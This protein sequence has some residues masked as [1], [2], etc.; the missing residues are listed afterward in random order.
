MNVKL[1]INRALVEH[2][3]TQIWLSEQTGVPTQT[4]MRMKRQ[5]N[6]PIEA[7]AKIADA[8]DMKLSDLIRMGE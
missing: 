7:L 4:L 2:D 1:A 6:A 8:L 5:N 3:K